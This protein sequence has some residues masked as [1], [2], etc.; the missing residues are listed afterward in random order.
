MDQYHYEPLPT[1]SHIRI[2]TIEAGLFGDD[3]RLSFDIVSFASD[4]CPS[5]DALSYT[6]DTQSSSRSV[7]VAEKGRA[8]AMPI[9][10]SLADVLVHLRYA[11]RP[12]VM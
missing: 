9:S 2:V 8:S 5:Y 12:R 11:D 7:Y 4:E 3:I 10:G 6:W 1:S